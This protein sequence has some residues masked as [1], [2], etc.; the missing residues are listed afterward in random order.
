MDQRVLWILND[1]RLFD[2]SNTTY[3]CVDVKGIPGTRAS[4]ESALFYLVKVVYNGGLPYGPY[5]QHTAII[6][7][8]FA[9][10]LKGTQ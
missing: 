6:I 3:D 7:I 4:V 2:Y 8:L 10:S 5:V 9:I 1:K